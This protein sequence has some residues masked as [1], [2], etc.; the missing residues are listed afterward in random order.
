MTIAISPP[1]LAASSQLSK[2]KS[3]PDASQQSA[4]TSKRVKVS[5]LGHSAAVSTAF[6][7]ELLVV[8]SLLPSHTI[9]GQGDG[10][11]EDVLYLLNRFLARVAD[12]VE[13]GLHRYQVGVDA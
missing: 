4:S 10:S 6:P 9:I 13:G 2:R 11:T 1:P 8:S 12:G 7:S 5:P 3:C